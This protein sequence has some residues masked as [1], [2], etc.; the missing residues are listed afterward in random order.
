MAMRDAQRTVK[1]IRQ[2]IGQETKSGS[3]VEY[4][5]GVVA[6]QYGNSADLY[7]NGNEAEASQNFRVPAGLVVNIGDYVIACIDYG[8]NLGKWINE[9]LPFDTYAKM[10]LN[11]TSGEWYESDGT[12]TPT[13]AVIGGGSG[14]GLIWSGIEF[15]YANDGSGD[16]FIWE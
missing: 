8:S 1:V 2:A 7:L 13:V 15:V 12:S 3:K 14:D 10:A 5:R 16:E 9:I 11:P 6:A 4:V